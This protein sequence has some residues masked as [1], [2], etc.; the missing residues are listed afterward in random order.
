[1]QVK[2]SQ[3]LLGLFF[4][5]HVGALADCPNGSPRSSSGSLSVH[6]RSLPE[7]ISSP[8][9][10]ESVDLPVVE[11]EAP[12]LIAPGVPVFVSGEFEND[13]TQCDAVGQR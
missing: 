11:N 13:T 6:S 8:T 3:C 9:S 1:M 7:F 2:T 12:G 4:S 10:P 5:E